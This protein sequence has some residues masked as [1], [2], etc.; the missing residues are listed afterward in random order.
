MPAP[1]R[2]S[3]MMASRWL[4]GDLGGHARLG[5]R[6]L[7]ERSRRRADGAG[8]HG[9]A[10]QVLE[11]EGPVG[12]YRGS[13]RTDGDELLAAQ[14]QP[15]QPVQVAGERGDAD[16]AAA[17]AHP[18]HEVGGRLGLGHAHTQAGMR[19]AELAH[20]PGHGVHDQRGQ[21]HQLEHARV[22][23]TKPTDDCVGVGRRL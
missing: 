12:R 14:P 8:D 2:T 5:E 1:A 6:R 19:A 18:V 17:I 3:G 10:G 11:H 21:G 22:T 15:P 9:R 13:G 4:V 20:E 16:L 7:H 23:P